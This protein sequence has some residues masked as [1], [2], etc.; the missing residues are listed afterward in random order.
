MLDHPEERRSWSGSA[1]MGEC[2]V[3]VVKPGG[4]LLERMS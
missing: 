1:L 4:L 3:M 2:M